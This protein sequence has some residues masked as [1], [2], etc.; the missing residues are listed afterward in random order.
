MCVSRAFPMLS[1]VLLIAAVAARAEVPSLAD[2]DPSQGCSAIKSERLRAAVL[3]PPPPVTTFDV[4]HYDLDLAIDLD[5]HTVDGACTISAVSLIPNLL[6]VPIDLH[7]DLTITSIDHDGTPLTFTRADHRVSITL[8]AAMSEDDAFAITIAYNGTPPEEGL[9]SFVFDTHAGTP[10]A[11]SLSEPWF[12]RTWWPCKETPT[13]KATC[14]VAITVPSEYVAVSNGLLVGVDDDGA[15]KTYRHHTDYPIATYLIAATVTN[16]TTW[17][18]IYVAG[19][20]TEMPL[21]YYVYPEDESESLSSWPV[22]AE[23]IELYRTVF[24]EYPFL[25]ERY[26]MVEFPFGGAME[27]QTMT[28][29]GS[30]CV[31]SELIIAHELAHQWW[32]DLVTCADWGHIWL[33]EGFATWSEGVWY[34]SQVPGGYADYMD[35]I[36]DPDG[37]DT[38]VYRYD[39]TNPWEIFS[40]VVYRKGAWVVHM[41]RGVL[42]EDD[43]WAGVLD[44]R[45]AHAYS[46]A[47][48][49]DLQAV[50]E[51]RS[52]QDLS[53]FFDEWIYGPGRPDYQYAYTVDGA[54][55]VVLTLDQQQSNLFTMPIEVDVVTTSGT[56]RFTIWN[57]APYQVFTLDVLT[58][59][60]TAIVFDP[61][62][63]ILDWHEEV[64]A[65][66][67][68]DVASAVTARVTRVAPQ[69]SAGV[70]SIELRSGRPY[71]DATVRLYDTTGRQV[72]TV[73]RGPIDV[74][75]L[76]LAWDGLGEDGHPA[77]PGVYYVTLEADRAVT[78]ERIVRVR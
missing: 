53:Y 56:E 18:D 24:G 48:T 13:D 30:C 22:V 38:P 8:D 61:D 54:G 19:D 58:G 25:A 66:G 60:P 41:L 39:L 59:T 31:G 23:Q 78:S 35:W 71:D 70:V 11:A 28:S 43:F 4:Q 17:T 62:N 1:T 27:H 34:G 65:V 77:A 51:S 45:A 75:T 42:G 10:L 33:N 6:S 12:A 37:F 32:G 69:P 5:A 7:D 49:E 55:D 74:G 68:P 67:T 76:R 63:W 47:T 3:G 57:D 52:G 15:T 14:D 36:D 72:A 73:H 16:F 40:G 21:E 20:G 29:M 50:M 26:G 46:H 9:Q 2:L 44:Y 64:T